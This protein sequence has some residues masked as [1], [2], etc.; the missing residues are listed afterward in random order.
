M[1]RTKGREEQSRVTASRAILHRSWLGREIR[2][3][4]RE[5]EES[6]EVSLDLEVLP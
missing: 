6:G 2:Q 5:L 1:G 4:R 3:R